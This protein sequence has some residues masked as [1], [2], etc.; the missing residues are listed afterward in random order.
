MIRIVGDAWR[1]PGR[2]VSSKMLIAVLS[3]HGVVSRCAHRLHLLALLDA[4]RCLARLLQGG[5]EGVGEG[6][7]RRRDERARAVV[8][9]GAEGEQRRRAALALRLLLELLVAVARKQELHENLALLLV[10]VVRGDSDC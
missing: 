3:V 4:L 7:E 2:G 6:G 10:V 8:L 9:R 1:G 5:G